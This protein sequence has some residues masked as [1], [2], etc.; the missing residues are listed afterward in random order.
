MLLTKLAAEALTA[1]TLMTAGGA[2]Y[3]FHK[4][5]ERDGIKIAENPDKMPID[6][7][8][9]WTKYFPF[10]RE[11]KAWLLAQ[12]IET[13]AI[14]SFDGLLLKGVYLPA[15]KESNK[16]VLAV[17]GYRSEG[18][19]EF[20]GLSQFYHEA[21]Y[22]VLVVDDRAHGESEGTYIGF[23]CLDRYDCKKWIAY[24]NERF[25][26]KLQIV[27]H[28]ISMGAATVVMASTMNLPDNVKAIIADCPFT[29]AWEV[30][31]HLLK[32]KYHMPE[33]PILS[34]T[35]LLCRRKAGYAFD[36]V[37]AM[38]EAMMMK[39]PLLVIH[40]ENDHFVPTYMGEEIFRACNA[41]KKKLILTKAGHGES[42]FA[43]QGAY[44]EAVDCF[45]ADC[46]Q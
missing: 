18:K 19:N 17:H 46:F 33:F 1:G 5:V 2:A 40:G 22:H 10:L 30:F 11:K 44:E 32:T 6:V 45:L 37:S 26:G 8:T 16:I 20:S 3:T 43:N 13:V 29:S 12:E 7:G 14:T 27:L 41:E 42:Y 35:S 23:G 4:V 34:A 9:D 24:I 31:S 21:G 36:E 38:K 15:K 25:E 39:Q 28:G